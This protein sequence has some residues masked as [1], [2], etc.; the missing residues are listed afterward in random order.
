MNIESNGLFPAEGSISRRRSF[1]ETLA[2]KVGQ[3]APG[4]AYRLSDS[5][6]FV[7]A[8]AMSCAATAVVVAR[9]VRFGSESHGRAVNHETSDGFLRKHSDAW[10]SLMRSRAV[11]A[12]YAQ[13]MEASKGGCLIRK[14][15]VLPDFLARV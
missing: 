11:G 15:A 5:G 6:P 10:T 9:T 14:V 3:K 4:R 8:E 7:S 2:S 12:F 13:K 1:P